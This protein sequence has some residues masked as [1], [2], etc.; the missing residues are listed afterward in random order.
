MFD[1]KYFVDGISYDLKLDA[2]IAAKGNINNI[3]ASIY[4]DR[5]YN[6]NWDIEPPESFDT[7]MKERAQQLRDKYSELTLSFSGGR[8]SFTILETFRKNNILLD[9]VQVGVPEFIKPWY[10]D[11]GNWEYI[12]TKPLIEEYRN[13][14]PKTNFSFAPY[15]NLSYLDNYEKSLSLV[16]LS[17]NVRSTLPQ[18]NTQYYKSANHCYLTGDLEPKLSL[19][20]N[21]WFIEIWDT[22]NQENYSNA[23]GTEAFYTHPDFP[24]LHA[25]QCYICKK[26]LEEL[27]RSN[28]LD[29]DSI[30]NLA[31]G[32]R[33][34]LKNLLCRDSHSV[35]STSNIPKGSYRTDFITGGSLSTLPEEYK[36]RWRDLYKFSIFGV[37][38]HQ[39]KFGI[40]T[41]SVSLPYN[42]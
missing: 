31:S 18:H 9:N 35:I 29:I 1:L 5:L 3:T 16:G 39:L 33:G 24:K 2:F 20:D 11:P 10:E 41:F 23:T 34:D 37:S 26:Y 7:L 8:D 30:K 38:L 12:N 14:M 13:L 28:K 4:N 17:S 25:K 19:S 27:I 21:T 15:N 22:E 42:A 6:F 40:K 32:Y 36:K